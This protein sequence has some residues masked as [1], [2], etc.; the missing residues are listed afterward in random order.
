VTSPAIPISK[1]ESCVRF[2]E[3][4]RRLVARERVR[5]HDDVVVGHEVRDPVVFEEALGEVEVA[6]AHLNR[7]RAGYVGA[8]EPLLDLAAEI[9]QDLAGD[10][11]R[12]LVAEHADVHP[13]PESRHP[14]CEAGSD[15]VGPADA[16]SDGLAHELHHRPRDP[17]DVSAVP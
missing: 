3:V 10:L 7:V 4:P 9:R 12:R 2:S 6:L 15:G 5:E 17:P 13:I 11:V 16:L 8:V 14:G 1:K